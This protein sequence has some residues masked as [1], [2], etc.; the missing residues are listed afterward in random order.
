MVLEVADLAAMRGGRTVFRAVNLV[1]PPGAALQVRG[2]NGAGKSTLLRTLAGLTPPSSGDAWHGTRS[3]SADREAYRQGIMLAGHEDAVRPEE[4][5]RHHLGFWSAL[6]RPGSTADGIA[7]ACHTLGLDQ[8][9]DLPCRYLS[10]GQRKR[11]ALARL[12]VSGAR[13]WL[14][15]E[16]TVTLDEDGRAR[17]AALLAS[18]RAAGGVAVLATHL[19]VE[20]PGSTHLVLGRSGG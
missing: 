20:L 1:L 8:L 2:V 19:V 9:I 15:D 13:V 7:A 14:M 5:P 3:L 18:H 16:P 17:L 10:A 11:L 6:C 12:A 4:T